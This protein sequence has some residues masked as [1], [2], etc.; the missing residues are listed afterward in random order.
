MI[1][2]EYQARAAQFHDITEQMPLLYNAA[3]LQDARVIE[4]GV[5]TGN[6]TAAFLAAAAAW[7][8]EVWSV[9][10][11]EPQVPESWRSLACWHLLVA[12]DRTKEAISFCPDDADVLFIDTSHS[13]EHTLAELRLYVPK[14]RPGGTVLLHDTK[15]EGTR[16]YPLGWPGV[17]RA[18]NDW[19]A[20]TGVSWRHVPGGPD[21]PG[22]GII[23]V[24]A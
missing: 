16:F 23:E 8:G 14:V 22:L 2:A 7:D 13:Y 21:S 5:R 17:S 9:D 24:P 18:L 3:C 11:A 12:D 19:S 6:S 1:T 15:T 20:E 4:L 10:V